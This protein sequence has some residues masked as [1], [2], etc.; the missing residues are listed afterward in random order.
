VEEAAE[1]SQGGGVSRVREA[2]NF[3]LQPLEWAGHDRRRQD[4]AHV[5]RPQQLQ[6]QPRAGGAD[7]LG[8]QSRHVE[9]FNGLAIDSGDEVAYVHKACGWTGWSATQG[10]ERAGKGGEGCT[11]H[12]GSSEWG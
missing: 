9:A 7:H 8:D 12:H 1:A 2:L 11:A 3:D 6:L 4:A 5:D 10:I